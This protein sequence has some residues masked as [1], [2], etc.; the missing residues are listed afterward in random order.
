MG[1]YLDTKK[2]L[3]M[4]TKAELEAEIAEL[5][6]QASQETQYKE[7][8][9]EPAQSDA[10]LLGLR[11]NMD[12]AKAEALAREAEFEAAQPRCGHVNTHSYGM[13]SKPDNCTCTRVIGHE[14]N[15]SALH[16][17]ADPAN[18]EAVTE[19]EREWSDAVDRP[20][21]IPPTAEEIERGMQ[22]QQ[23]DWVNAR[24]PTTYIE[25]K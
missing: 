6:L 22:A 4:S 17:E 5:K 7:A 13:D 15:H 19:I 24:T 8:V 14:D 10:E 1:I 2:E 21:Y 3:D 23:P 9:E 18:P 16:E 20:P 25:R 11:E 12:K